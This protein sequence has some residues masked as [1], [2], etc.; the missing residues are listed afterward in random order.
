M[1]VLS[2]SLNFDQTG[3]EHASITNADFLSNALK[4]VAKLCQITSRKIISYTQI[5]HLDF[6]LQATANYSHALLF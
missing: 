2:P 1:Y 5:V 6:L 3:N 4:I